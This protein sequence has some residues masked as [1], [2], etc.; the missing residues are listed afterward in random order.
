M[1][2]MLET[3]KDHGKLIP[4]ETKTLQVH[5][6]TTTTAAHSRARRLDAG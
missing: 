6:T 4:T 1:T 3:E 5:T 2:V